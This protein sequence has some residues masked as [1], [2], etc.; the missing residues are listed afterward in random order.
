MIRTVENVK[1]GI[2]QQSG[3]PFANSNGTYR[4][5]IPHKSN[6]VASIAGILSDRSLTGSAI[7]VAACGK[8]VKYS[9]RQSDPPKS[10]TGTRPK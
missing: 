1:T 2:L 7:H 10:A 8:A 4:I 5:G 9:D 3:Q 6:V